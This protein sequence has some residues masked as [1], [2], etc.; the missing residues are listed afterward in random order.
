MKSLRTF[1]NEEHNCPPGKKYCPKCQMCVAE[2]CAE[3][4]M[5][6]EENK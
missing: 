2:T 4:K 6:K 1:F 5:R 3:K